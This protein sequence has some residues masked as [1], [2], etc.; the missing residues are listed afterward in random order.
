MGLIEATQGTDSPAL[1]N[2]IKALETIAFNANRL[3][4]EQQLAERCLLIMRKAIAGDHPWTAGALAKT[5]WLLSRS[6]Q[7]ALGEARVQQGL[8][9]F[10]RLGVEADKEFVAA[11]HW[12]AMS[13]E[14]RG[15][16]PSAR[17]TLDRAVEYCRVGALQSN[18]TCLT[19][20]AH[21][22]Q[23]YI[24]VGEQARS[25]VEIDAV[26]AQLKVAYNPNSDDHAR[27]LEA[28][29]AALLAL[30]RRPEAIVAQREAVATY[31]ALYGA[32]REATRQ[33]AGQLAVM[34]GEAVTVPP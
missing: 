17:S 4:E 25:L 22:A 7:Y 13:Q 20:R 10:V 2:L 31:T 32:Q 24:D 11:L 30:Q 28:R 33:A 27:A 1:Y 9:M 19:T 18:L 6:G 8:D 29:A 26:I 23:L 15:D 14:R 16:L 3:D 21:R 5:G 12:L 34:G